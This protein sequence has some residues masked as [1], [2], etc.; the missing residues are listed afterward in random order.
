MKS[1]RAYIVTRA[2]LSLP[3][4]FILVTLVFFIVR[5]MPGDPVE[6][7]LRPGV[8][9]EYKN[10][11]K[12]NLGLDRPLFLNFRGSTA[13]VEPEQIFLRAEPDVAGT[14]TLLVSGGSVLEI[15]DRASGDATWLQ[16]AVPE[17]FVGWVSPD[18][19]DWMRQ[20]NT[21]MT[22]LEEAPLPGTSA[23]APLRP[24][25]APPGVETS[26]IWAQPS[27]LVWVGTDEGVSRYSDNGWDHFAETDGMRVLAIWSGRP[28]DLW[29]GTDGAGLLHVRSNK[30]ATFGTADGLPSD[31]VLAVWGKG[32]RTLWVGTDQGA[33]F[34]DGDEWQSYT[35]SDG[36][37]GNE[38]RAVWGDGKGTVW[39][40]TDA[41]LS[42][43]DGEAWTSWTHEDGLPADSVRALWGADGVLWIGTDAGL[44]R[45][46]ADSDGG[47]WNI[48]TTADGLASDQVRLIQGDASGSLWVGTASGL[49][50]YDG[51]SWVSY[52]LAD[53]LSSA[54]V[55]AV[56]QDASGQI[57]AGTANGLDRL[58]S[59]PWIK[60]SV[61]A[62]GMDGWAPADQFEVGV[63][64]FD[65]QYFNYLWDLGHLDLGVSMA[66]TRGR[67]VA[68]DLK[69]KLPATL[70][71]SISAL[72]MTVLVGIPAGAFA[73]HK[74]RSGADY[75]LR[76]FSIVIWAV[77]VFWLGIMFQLVF[78]VYMADWYETSMIGQK[79]LQPIF[80]SFLPLP[81][82][83]RIGT[84]MAPKTITG[85]YVVD[86]LLSGNWE[87][88]KSALRYLILPSVTL[89]LYLSGVFTR[90]TRSNM[91]DTLKEDFITAAR[92][93]GI[94]EHVVVYNHAL[95]NAFIPVLT[96]MGL[97][98]AALL[99]G[100]VLTETTFSWPGMGLFMWERIGYRDFNSIQGAVVIFAVLVS[101][102]S[103]L[104]DI[105]YAW[106]DPRIRY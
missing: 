66:P 63:K 85:L 35:T 17:G 87:A 93:R 81:I 69:Q 7:M 42:R 25:D 92:A 79:V 37:V 90:L 89:G 12:H 82:S 20:V 72:V 31:T 55:R 88:V 27:G 52:S 3:M 41:G 29:F 67:P 74:R 64:P 99:A 34:Y 36:L 73:A 14:K 57:W 11:I 22:V 65:S 4:L 86:G 51:A 6:A 15:S 80:G 46:E 84:E 49:S 78:G 5:I 26:A 16:V 33:A 104:V 97:Q 100:A 103:L 54:E 60:L 94:K 48:L 39:F 44:V 30:W 106:I 43:F 40:G 105:I 38:V 50:Y 61:P 32:S 24:A 8:P 95:K 10:Q 83:G 98:F 45:Y 77:P 76:I 21:E 70:E 28:A 62:G 58:D 1:L 13:R 53:G 59:R 2:L 102:V 101:A 56:A 75:A 23:W 18:Q 91:L 71:L 9:E 19:M 68:L 47:Q 96:M